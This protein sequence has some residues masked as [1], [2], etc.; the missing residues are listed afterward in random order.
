[1]PIDTVEDAAREDHI[2][3][4]HRWQPMEG[5]DRLGPEAEL[6]R[7]ERDDLPAIDVALAHELGDVGKEP[8]RARAL[9]CHHLDARAGARRP[10]V[11]VRPR[12][13]RHERCAAG[14]HEIEADLPDR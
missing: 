11:L 12:D 7:A 13:E 10:H 6:L 3:T 1:M 5:D 2:I 9:W 4:R 14:P 8:L